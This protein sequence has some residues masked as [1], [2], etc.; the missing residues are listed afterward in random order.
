MMI[1]HMR[2]FLKEWKGEFS[3]GDILN[4]IYQEKSVVFVL[5]VLMIIKL[6]EIEICNPSW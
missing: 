6:D 4:F 3:N 1:V 5:A 2:M